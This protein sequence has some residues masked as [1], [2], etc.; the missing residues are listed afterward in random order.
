MFS[1]FTICSWVIIRRICSLKIF[2]PTLDICELLNNKS[3][4]A[5]SLFIKHNS[6]KSGKFFNPTHVYS[7]FSRIYVFQGHVFLG[8]QCFSGSR[9]LR[10]QVFQG[11]GPRSRVRVQVL[12]VALC[13]Y[14]EIIL[15]HRCSPV[16][17]LSISEHLFIR[18]PFPV[19]RERKLN[20]HK[21][22]RRRPGLLLNV[23][24]TFNLRPLST[25]GLLLYV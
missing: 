4:C 21:T 7:I 3:Y 10:V 9:S 12:E 16:T 19:D 5:W 8:R 13:T 20:V 15:W 23:L 14:M 6:I 22:F 25:E 17:L 1:G 18:T 24:C 2:S 11:L